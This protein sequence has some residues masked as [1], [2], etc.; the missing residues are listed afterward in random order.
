MGQNE[1]KTE[2]PATTPENIWCCAG[3]RPK[4]SLHTIKEARRFVDTLSSTSSEDDLNINHAS[5]LSKCSVFTEDVHEFDEDADIMFSH[6]KTHY[7]PDSEQLEITVEHLIRYLC[8]HF[9]NQYSLICFATVTVFIFA[10]VIVFQNKKSVLDI[11]F[12]FLIDL[13]IVISGN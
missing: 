12:L 11:L 1:S 9:N 3:K 8:M 7:S 5:F 4:G 2:G 13:K 10:V 6:S